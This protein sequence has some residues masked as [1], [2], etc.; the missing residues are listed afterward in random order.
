MVLKNKK[1]IFAVDHLVNSLISLLV[2]KLH[3]YFTINDINYDCKVIYQHYHISYIEIQ[4]F[5]KLDDVH[6]E[7][8]FCYVT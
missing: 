1:N 3:L 6:T 4:I 5:K 2:G 7:I 8:K